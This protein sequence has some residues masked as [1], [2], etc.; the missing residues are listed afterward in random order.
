MLQVDFG[1]VIGSHLCCCCC[2]CPPQVLVPAN[3]IEVLELATKASMPG[4]FDCFIEAIE[5]AGITDMVTMGTGFTI[6][7]PNNTVFT[8]FLTVRG[9]NDTSNV[10]CRMSNV[11]C[12]MS[13]VEC[14]LSN[15]E[16]RL[17]TVECRMSTVECRLSNVDCQLSN[18]KYRLSTV[19]CQLSNVD[20]RLPTVNSHFDFV[21]L[22]LP[23]LQQNSADKEHFFANPDLVKILVGLHIIPSVE[24]LAEEIG[25]TFY[26]T[27]SGGF[28]TTTNSKALS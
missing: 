10:E 22:A 23:P 8:T 13:T 5:V 2:C 7:V 28:V 9:D 21:P 1:F 12:R 19:D 25:N 20:C 16:C 15:V 26:Q 4:K 6:F 18:V 24:L 14:R 17:S 27:F 3:V 11:E